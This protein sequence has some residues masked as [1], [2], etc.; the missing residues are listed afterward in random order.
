MRL[1]V[2]TEAMFHCS[3]WNNGSCDSSQEGLKSGPV[4]GLPPAPRDPLHPKSNEYP[5][6]FRNRSSTAA[7]E[8]DSTPAL[9]DNQF[10]GGVTNVAEGRG[11]T[12]SGRPGG[13]EGAYSRVRGAATAKRA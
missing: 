13:A 11:V 8:A 5:P 2:S 6:R 10:A 12:P 9:A 3:T 7:L 4:A 1:N